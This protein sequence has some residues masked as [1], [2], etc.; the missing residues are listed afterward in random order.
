MVCPSRQQCVGLPG[1][2]VDVSALQ[3]PL[4]EN[5]P[6]WEAFK[7]STSQ[8]VEVVLAMHNLYQRP[9]AY[10]IEVNPDVLKH[11]AISGLGA[12]KQLTP[13]PEANDSPAP[14]D[15]SV[16]RGGPDLS[17]QQQ[18]PP[19][20]GG[21]VATSTTA[22]PANAAG[23][24]AADML[25]AAVA[26]AQQR[27]Q[28]TTIAASMAGT[29]PAASAAVAASIP[30][31]APAP[32]PAPAPQQRQDLDVVSTVQQVRTKFIQQQHMS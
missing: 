13:G 19:G 24:A 16:I 32:A 10:Y 29:G 17:Q 20:P 18:A 21:P 25:A 2:A 9:K 14:Q 7:V 26:A 28:G 15:S 6:W 23:I 11:A 1:P 3:V 27:L 12:V 30:T 8:V 22:P 4:P 5:P 31:P